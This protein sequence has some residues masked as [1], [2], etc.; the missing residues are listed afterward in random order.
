[1]AGHGVRRG[2]RLPARA[3]GD[4]VRDGGHPGGREGVLRE[5]RPG[6]ERPVSDAS[7]V[8]LRCRTSDRT[9]GG[10]RGAE[11]LAPRIARLLGVEARMIGTPGEPRSASFEDD[12]RDSRGCLLEAGGQVDDALSGGRFPVLLASDCSICMTT[13]PTV[14]RHVPETRVLWLDAHGDFNTPGTT[15]SGF[16][17]GMCLAAACG[18]WEA[19]LTEDGHVDPARVVMTGVRDLD[20]G[21]R[22][23]LERAGIGTVAPERLA[24]AL[25]DEAVYVHLD[26]DVLDPDEFPAQF[27]APDG[28]SGGAL[29]DLLGELAEGSRLVGV[30]TTALEA[31]AGEE[32]RERL[33]VS[34][35]SI[36]E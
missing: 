16:L 34:V 36:V 2:A 17:G 1:P 12:L 6:L 11:A 10:V 3:V 19:G 22:V 21:E 14:L 24:G 27:P 18:R 30:E 7:V 35:Q 31:A 29:V 5:A 15:P 9:P 32:E 20:G 33:G 26:L 4:R 8:A 13:L 23:E 28:L 25:E